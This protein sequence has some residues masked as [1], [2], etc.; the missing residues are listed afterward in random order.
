VTR[1]AVARWGALLLLF[2]SG[3][4]APLLGQAQPL[5]APAPAVAWDDATPV[6]DVPFVP[7][8][9]ALCGGAAVAMV[10]RY[11]GE[12][13]VYAEDFAP[14][15][16]ATGEGIRTDDLAAAVRQRG[17]MARPFAGTA[18]L[19]QRELADGQ[20]VI[21]LIEVRPG[22]YHYVVLIAWRAGDVVLHDP[23][24]GPLRRLDED[25][26]VRAWQA[27]GR[28]SMRVRPTAS[29]DAPS[30]PHALP[31]SDTT[32]EPDSRAVPVA[33]DRCSVLID[34][35]VLAARREQPDSA[36]RML[37]QAAGLCPDRAAVLLEL[38]AVRFRQ[39]RYAAAA[40][41]ATAVIETQPSRSDA[42]DLLASSRYLLDDADGAL[43]AWN[44]I[45]RPHN[46]LTRIDGLRATPY[47][48][49]NDAIDIAPGELVSGE[50]LLRA[51]RRVT[52][53]P[54]VHRARVD[55][56]PLHGG[57]VEVQAA[58]VEKSTLPVSA[59]HLIVHGVRALADSRLRLD[60]ANAMRLGEAWLLDWVWQRNRRAVELGFAAPD[61]LDVGGVWQLHF[62]DRAVTYRVTSERADT[63]TVETV[64]REDYHGATIG[65][66]DWITGAIRWQ[67]TASLDGWSDRGGFASV[68]AH[69]QVRGL[70]DRVALH[71]GRGG[72]WSLGGDDAFHTSNLYAVIRSSSAPQS[73]EWTARTGIAFASDSA[74]RTHWS[75]A[76]NHFAADA[77]LR[78]HPLIDGDGVITSS[79]FAPRLIH[80]GVELR[81]WLPRLGP[82]QLGAATFIDAA[83]VR[84]PNPGPSRIAIDI[85]AGLRFRIG[86]LPGAI[87]ADAALGLTDGV[88]AL[89]LGW[90]PPWPELLNP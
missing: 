66:S 28:W 46:D 74:P 85:G 48:T 64:D 2:C 34:E 18:E 68:A 17:W 67:L 13:G 24:R 37:L 70:R 54:T 44:R 49:V 43:R 81:R 63:G 15:V 57:D 33:I 59:A 61:V 56:R 4:P 3:M 1:G 87:R 50:S 90:A 7:Q 82:L 35:A 11:Y 22:R 27:S 58:I 19:V 72:W 20:P 9:P 71:A 23:A 52:A 75:G 10:L 79:F 60:V 45:E 5:R 31:A 25:R 26:F 40:A 69:V 89:S 39:R 51:R 47:H 21:A 76:G 86:A 73:V 84:L 42:W 12:R 78:A 77:L 38:A 16:V 8:T 6:L 14:L 53:L 29:N 65:V 30:T 41:A 80:A 32:V 83:H 88:A 62:A 55:Y 36:E